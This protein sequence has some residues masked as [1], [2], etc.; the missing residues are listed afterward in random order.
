MKKMR[1]LIMGS[2]GSIGRQ[3]LEVVG[4]DHDFF[5]VVGLTARRNEALL[6]E[7]ANRCAAP[8][9]LTDNEAALCDFIAHTPADMVVIA[10]SGASGLEPTLAAIRACRAVALAN[11]ET[12]VMDGARVMD[13]VRQHHGALFPIDSEHSALAQLLARFDRRQVRSVTLTCSGGAFRGNS[14]EELRDVTPAQALKHPTWSMGPKITID[15]AT[16][17]NKGFEILEAHHL[18]GLPFDAIRALVHPESR[19][20]A[21][22]ELVDGTVWFHASP[23][24]MR[25]PIHA[26]LHGMNT[27]VCGAFESEVEVGILEPG[28]TRFHFES[29]EAFPQFR[30]VQLALEAARSGP[31][32]C[33]ALAQADDRAVEE[34]LKGRIEFLEIYDRLES[35]IT[36]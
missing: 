26:A 33:R 8:A 32:A 24:D 18:F 3:V 22:V 19:V 35:A 4:Q 29:P 17:V 9:L 27:E 20:H 12:L 6:H 23:P 2:T 16:W 5:E 13:E 28:Q 34:F 21:L 15:S 7:Q 30:G 36:A 25:I 1:V 31:A 14:L 11:K 10:L